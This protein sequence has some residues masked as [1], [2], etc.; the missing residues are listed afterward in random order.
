MGRR[1]EQN[2][3][4]YMKQKM[5]GVKK[6]LSHPDK[7]EILSKLIL[8]IDPR[9]IHDHLNIKYVNEP[10]LVISV[11]TLKSFRDNHLDVYNM[12]QEDLQKTRN[13]LA[14]NTEDDLELSVR[15]NST[16]KTRMKELAN[17]ELDVRKM[18]VRMA[19]NL[20]D[21]FAIIFDQIM[22]DPRNIN[23][24]ID[25][26]MLEYAEVLGNLLDKYFRF[27]E[28]P[29]NIGI[30]NNVSIQVIDSHVSIIQDSIKECLELMD[31]DS[32]NAFMNILTEKMNKLKAPSAEPSL[33]TDAKLAEVKLLNETINQ[34]LNS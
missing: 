21:R 11:S 30:Q 9:D 18:I 1:V 23:T 24:R 28:A 29:S 6:L 27:T 19:T 14:T 25:R 4:P 17:N 34:K 7:E 13:A 15:D 3:G 22:E 31:L 8:N 5:A 10:K 20:E 32:G 26:L 12:L 33:N 16:Y 2:K